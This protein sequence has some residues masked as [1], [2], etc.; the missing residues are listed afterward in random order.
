MCHN[1]AR[2]MKMFSHLNNSIVGNGNQVKICIFQYH[3][4]IIG[5]LCV[6]LVGQFTRCRGIPSKYLN[7]AMSGLPEFLPQHCGSI[8][9]TYDN[10]IHTGPIVIK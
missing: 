10:Y 4:P 7:N 9:R 5:R 2:Y 3:R 1:F 6:K 8:P